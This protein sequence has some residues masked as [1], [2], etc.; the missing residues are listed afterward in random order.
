[1]IFGIVAAVIVVAVQLVIVYW[2]FLS[3]S[4]GYRRGWDDCVQSI[5]ES[6]R[7]SMIQSGL[8]KAARNN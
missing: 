1:M 2:A 5:G 4:A 7:L 3:F 8:A 6:A